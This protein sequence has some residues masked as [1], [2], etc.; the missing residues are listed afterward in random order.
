MEAIIRM[1]QRAISNGRNNHLGAKHITVF[2][3]I[4]RQEGR[5][6][7]TLM[8]L[9]MLLNKPAQL[10]RLVP[11]AFKM[12]IRGKSPFPFK[13]PIRGILKIREFFKISEERQ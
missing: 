11:L 4:V 1:R 7:E 3:N 8:P 5:L 12:L 9:K 2:S 6:N 10:L 13:K